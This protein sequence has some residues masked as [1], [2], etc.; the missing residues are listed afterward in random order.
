MIVTR[1]A[2]WDIRE[3]HGTRHGP[4][5]A[6]LRRRRDT[7][8]SGRPPA[9]VTRGRAH[10]GPLLSGR[11]VL[12]ALATLGDRVCNSSAVSTRLPSTGGTW[13]GRAGRGRCT[14]ATHRR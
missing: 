14:R 5:G 12:A 6:D 2:E 7:P 8:A 10:F 4:L 1:S 9:L 13:F 3:D 11:H